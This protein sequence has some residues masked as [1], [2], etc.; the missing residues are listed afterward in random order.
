MANKEIT[1]WRIHAGSE[2]QASSLF[3]KKGVIA[4]GRKDMGDYRESNLIEKHI[5]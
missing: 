3:T 2:G 4:I 5:T 1:V